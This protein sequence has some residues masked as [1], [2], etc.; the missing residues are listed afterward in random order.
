MNLG[1]PIHNISV[2]PVYLYK[3]RFIVF[4]QPISSGLSTLEQNDCSFAAD[5]YMHSP[6][7]GP[8]HGPQSSFYTDPLTTSLRESVTSIPK[9]SEKALR[10]YNWGEPYRPQWYIWAFWHICMYVQPSL[11]RRS[12]ALKELSHGSAYAL[13]IT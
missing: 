7:H 3:Q 6:V 8:V 5:L 2:V 13:H 9:N 10:D 4:L 1:I 12:A 11:V